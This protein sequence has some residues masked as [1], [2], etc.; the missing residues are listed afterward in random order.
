MFA[1][2]SILALNAASCVGFGLL[3]L[4]L[5]GAVAAFLGTPPAPAWLIAGLGALLVV[6]GAH[7]A[8]AAR[9]RRPR[10]ALVLYFS[11]GD[12]AWVIATL[13]LIAGGVWINRPGGIASALLV[14]AGVGA[15][16]VLQWRAS[17]EPGR[18]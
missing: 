11:G 7:L 18:G 17:R 13:A 15:L 2:A 6:H 1:L 5:P 16:G 4:A 10:R 9:R 12:L 14:A 3:F 8:W